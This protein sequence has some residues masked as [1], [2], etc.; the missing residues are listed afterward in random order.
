MQMLVSCR[1]P[2]S[3]GFTLLEILVVLVLVGLVGGL[4]IPRVA[5]IYDNLLLRG[6]RQD[7]VRQVESLSWRALSDGRV[8]LLGRARQDAGARLDM[9]AGWKLVADP[10]VAFLANG[11]CGGGKFSLHYLA[12][13]AW[14]YQLKAPFCKPEPASDGA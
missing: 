14:H 5:V 7:I 10:A 1:T 3:A 4:V 13:R 8:I 9:P 6:E 2:D 12:D 11:F